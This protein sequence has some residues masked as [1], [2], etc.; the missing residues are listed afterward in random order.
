MSYL[1]NFCASVLLISLI[2][3]F[4]APYKRIWPITLSSN[5][6]AQPA[7]PLQRANEHG[8]TPAQGREIQ[9]SYYKSSTLNVLCAT[10]VRRPRQ[11]FQ[12]ITSGCHEYRDEDGGEYILPHTCAF[13]TDTLVNTSYRILKAGFLM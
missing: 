7:R 11:E 8:I 5:P 3:I 4:Q 12:P 2:I 13:K 6:T 10:D 9:P 1:G